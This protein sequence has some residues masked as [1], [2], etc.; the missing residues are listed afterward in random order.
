MYDFLAKESIVPS[1]KERYILNSLPHLHVARQ[2]LLAYKCREAFGYL[3]GVLALSAET[4]EFHES[5]F[6]E[7]GLT[8][9][10]RT[11]QGVNIFK[12]QMMA[13]VAD[14]KKRAQKPDLT[15]E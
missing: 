2:A 13:L 10:G 8:Q 15:D 4:F 5:Y 9:R 12:Q 11:T 3:N 6:N 1:E 14:S 7:Y